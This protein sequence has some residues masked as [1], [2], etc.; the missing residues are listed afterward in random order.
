MKPQIKL[1]ETQ[2]PDGNTLTLFEHDGDYH[3]RLN[4]QTL[5][6]SRHTASAVL[7]GEL[8]GCASGRPTPSVLIG[9]LGLGFTLKSVLAH[10]PRGTKIHVVE[11]IPAVVEWNRDILSGLN[12]ALLEKPGVE[13]FVEDVFQLLGRVAP[14]SY[15]VILLDIDNGPEAM[16]QTGN[17]RLYENEGIR[18]ISAALKPGGRAAIWSAGDDQDFSTRLSRA[19]FKVEVVRAKLHPNAKR[20]SH[21]IFVADKIKE[22]PR[23]QKFKKSPPRRK[24]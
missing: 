4:N 24:P 10:V 15:D 14:A 5:M 12:G 20:F 21:T 18:R 1:A 17:G 16:V 6:N 13:V 2:T 22:T 7:L 23:V 3:I 19:D 11:L 8:A 9:G